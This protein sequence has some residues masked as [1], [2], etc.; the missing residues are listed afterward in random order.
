MKRILL[1]LF[2]S[3]APL[4]AQSQQFSFCETA[5]VTRNMIFDRAGHC[6][7][8]ALGQNLFN[9]AD[10]TVSGPTLSPE[11]A[12]FVAWAREE[13]TRVGCNLPT[14]QGAWPSIRAAFDFYNQFWTVPLPL[15]G[16]SACWGY[17]GAAVPVRLGASHDA[18]Q[19]GSLSPGQSYVSVHFGAH[20][21]DFI[22][23][24]TGP[25][26]QDIVTGWAQPEFALDVCDQVAG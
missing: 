8:S 3:M 21:W 25:S 16:G 26:G 20:N 23:V 1:A 9:N 17:H 4:A 22:T 15:D 2:L 18:P 6:F 19:I 11:L 5:W 7:G 10:C 24:M 14:G 13:E 12:E